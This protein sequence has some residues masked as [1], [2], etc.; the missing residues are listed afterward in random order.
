MQFSLYCLI[1]DRGNWKQALEYVTYA[2]SKGFQ[3]LDILWMPSIVAM[4][5]L[6]NAH[7]QQIPWTVSNCNYALRP[8]TLSVDYL[9]I[10]SRSLL[11]LVTVCYC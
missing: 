4:E 5:N 3:A 6:L 2:L 10:V 11:L 1:G 9:V 8:L 7:N